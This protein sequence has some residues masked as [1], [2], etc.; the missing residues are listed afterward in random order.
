MKINH[1]D[2]INYKGFQ[3]RDKKSVS[4]VAEKLSLERADDVVNVLDILKEQK[5][6]PD[7]ISIGVDANMI[8]AENMK[9]NSRKYYHGIFQKITDFFREVVNQTGRESSVTD[10]VHGYG[11]T[12]FYQNDI[13][14]K[15]E[16]T[17]KN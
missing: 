9:D 8:Y 7:I 1:I 4:Q 10:K 15:I 2:N 14:T 3:F 16:E 5:N 13:I 12:H 6:N 17:M 11:R